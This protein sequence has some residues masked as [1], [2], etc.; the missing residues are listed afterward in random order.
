M[1]DRR[2]PSRGFLTT[3]RKSMG[4]YG[5]FGNVRF[6][7]LAD[8]ASSYRGVRFT[9]GKR[10]LIGSPLTSINVVR[11]AAGEYSPALPHRRVR[12]DR[13]PKKVAGRAPIRASARDHLSSWNKTKDLSYE[14]I[15]SLAVPTSH[16]R[17]RS[18]RGAM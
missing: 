8:V 18:I 3:S 2:A 11:I 10:T 5:Q 7:S 4:R 13:T 12:W 1:G 17:L 15:V 14:A 16:T 6:G 9:P